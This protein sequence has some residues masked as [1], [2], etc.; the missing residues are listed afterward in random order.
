MVLFLKAYH[1]ENLNSKN[2]QSLITM[3]KDIFV[4]SSDYIILG[5]LTQ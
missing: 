5:Y 2:F 4:T 1:I 3:G